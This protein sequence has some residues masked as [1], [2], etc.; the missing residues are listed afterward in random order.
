MGV[1]L[2]NLILGLLWATP[3]YGKIVVVVAKDSSLPS[4]SLDLVKDIYLGK[5]REV[6]GSG[7]VQP[8]DHPES[9]PV[10][11]EFCRDVLGKTPQQLKSYWSLR[12][13]TGRGTPPPTKGGDVEVKQWLAA[14]KSGIGYIDAKSVD[15]SVKVVLSIP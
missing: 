14:N 12:I 13:F 11:S 3:S 2:R 9:S 10:W 8:V 15:E 5:E 6:K 4:L 1:R 7:V